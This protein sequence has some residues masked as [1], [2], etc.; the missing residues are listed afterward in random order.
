MALSHELP[1]PGPDGLDHLTVEEMKELLCAI[2][3]FQERQSGQLW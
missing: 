2:Q 3:E 1:S